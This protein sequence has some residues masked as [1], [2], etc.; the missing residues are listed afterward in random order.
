M[1]KEIDDN[2]P[3]NLAQFVKDDDVK[4]K[5]LFEKMKERWNGI[6]TKLKSK[7]SLFENG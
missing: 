2:L 7:A 5:D 4:S 1:L 6:S 3:E